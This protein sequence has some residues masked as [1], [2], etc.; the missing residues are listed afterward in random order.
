MPMPIHKVAVAMATT[1]AISA[2]ALLPMSSAFADD[3]PVAG[4]TQP[5]ADDTTTPAPDDTSTPSTD[6]SSTPAADDQ[7]DDQSESDDQSDDQ[8]QSAPVVAFSRVHVERDGDD[9]VLVDWRF[10]A[11]ATGFSV[12]VTSSVG[13]TVT[14]DPL[15]AGATSVTIRTLAPDT[16]YT[17]TVTALLAD[18]TSVVSE[19]SNT[20]HTDKSATGKAA[21]KAQKAAKQAAKRAKQLAEQAA[22][23]QKRAQH[24]DGKAAKVAAKQAAAASRAAAKATRTAHDLEHAAAKAAS[25]ARHQQERDQQDELGSDS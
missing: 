10:S 13:G 9:A 21:E 15:P 25:R 7:S 1:A 24:A 2:F 12:T 22:K 6:D 14:S 20:V 23:A 18:G 5:A 8:D 19:R 4:Q 11:P 17:A 16:R 3:Q